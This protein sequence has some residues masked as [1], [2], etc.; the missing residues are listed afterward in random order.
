M[1]ALAEQ[2]VQKLKLPMQQ[3]LERGVA[4]AALALRGEQLWVRER[5]AEALRQE[6]HS[7]CAEHRKAVREDLAA[8]RAE[9]LPLLGSSRGMG[10]SDTADKIEESFEAGRRDQASVRRL[11]EQHAQQAAAHSELVKVVLSERDARAH[12]FREA[13]ETC[14]VEARRNFSA[15]VCGLEARVSR[16]EDGHQTQAAALRRQAQ[17]LEAER[18]ASSLEGADLRSQL[19]ALQDE[20]GK[21]ASVALCGD[22]GAGAPASG[23]LA[24]ISAD[25]T[26]RLEFGLSRLE[27]IVGSSVRQLS[28]ELRTECEER[29]G[30]VAE[31]RSHFGAFAVAADSLT[32]KL[33]RLER[34]VEVQCAELGTLRLRD[35]PALQAAASLL[36]PLAPAPSEELSRAVTRSSSEPNFRAG[37]RENDCPPDPAGVAAEEEDSSAARR[38]STRGRRASSLGAAR[39]VASMPAFPSREVQMRRVELVR[40]VMSMGKSTDEA[41]RSFEASGQLPATR[42]ATAP[43][44]APTTALAVPGVEGLTLQQRRVAMIKQAMAS[45]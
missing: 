16:L 19:R 22:E 18:K 24:S 13:A 11:A 8:Q 12:T 32:E 36:E 23:T 26:K 9:L 31:L 29:C 14:V 28:Q 25:V 33:A 1:T 34:E 20:L 30:N 10:V 7:M 40:R 6:L 41:D 21:P 38:A 35:P 3:S 2:Q 43:A 37:C 42:D 5:G 39:R 44:T 45:P 4:D 17:A 15:E 27:D